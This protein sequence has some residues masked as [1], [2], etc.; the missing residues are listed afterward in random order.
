MALTLIRGGQIYDATTHTFVAGDVLLDGATI[1]AVGPGDAS[2]GTSAIAQ[3]SVLGPAGV[4]QNAAGGITVIDAAGAYVSAGFIDSHTHIF[5]H[6]L[7]RTRRL[8]ADRIGVQQGVAC[9]VDAGSFGAITVDAFPR[10]VHET[11]HTR[12][13]AFI[14]IGSPGLPNLGA[15][16]TSRPDLCDLPGVV[17][18]FDRHGDWLLGVKVLASASHTE[19]FGEQAV[20]MAIKAAEL[21]DLP[22]MLHIGNAPPVIDDVLD[23]LRPG[24]II[25]HVYH[26]KVGG[27]LTYKDRVLPAFRAAIAR[28]VYADIG[29][30]QASFSFRTCERA[31]EQGM[32][33]H[34]ISSDLHAGNVDKYA[35]SLARTMTKLLTLGL[36]LADVVRAVTTTP[37]KMLR[38]DA[39]GFGTLAVGAP[40]HVTVFDVL[41]ES[42]EIEDA[43]RDKRV[44][45]QWIQPRGVF[46]SGTW[47]A[48]TAGL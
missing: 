41:Q 7:F 18:A 24:D 21:V 30:G 8:A 34:A 45:T 40:A 19:S 16:H 42:H 46:V 5:D 27:V 12:A 23:M 36:S 44:A 38:L 2:S 28:G 13:Y 6:P 33:V 43:E 1:A 14:N 47:H 39:R 22:V 9:C 17:K 31:L 32:P 35:F 15:G 20:K 10:F 37:A 4:G 3:S 25:T 11:Q 48:R 26:G 29:H